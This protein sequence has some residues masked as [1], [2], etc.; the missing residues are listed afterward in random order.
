[1]LRLL[2]LF[3]LMLSLG[4]CVL[5]GGERAHLIDKDADEI[6]C[7]FSSYIQTNTGEILFNNFKGDRFA[8]NASIPY[9]GFRNNEIAF[10][11]NDGWR[12]IL[13]QESTVFDINESQSISMLENNVIAVQRVGH[14][15][16]I[17]FLE[18][19]R[20][21][22]KYLD[23]EYCSSR[24]WLSKEITYLDA[25]S[26][27]SKCNTLN[28]MKEESENIL[29]VWLGV[30]FSFAVL[31]RL[32]DPGS[33]FIKELVGNESEVNVNPTYESVRQIVSCGAAVCVVTDNNVISLAKTSA[34]G[35]LE[36]DVKKADHT[37]SGFLSYNNVKMINSKVYTIDYYSRESMCSIANGGAGPLINYSDAIFG[38]IRISE[39]LLADRRDVKGVAVYFHGGPVSYA[40]AGNEILLAQRYARLGYDLIVPIYS[41]TINSSDNQKENI[42]VNFDNATLKD[43]E[44]VKLYIEKHYSLDDQ[45][46][47]TDIIFHGVSWGGLYYSLAK[48]SELFDKYLLVA[49]LVKYRQPVEYYDKGDRK[50]INL[51]VAEYKQESLLGSQKEV[52]SEI[53]EGR[54]K[55]CKANA[56]SRVVLVLGKNDPI[57]QFEDFGNCLPEDTVVVTYLS[58]PHHWLNIN[59]DQMISILLN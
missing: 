14:I 30:N 50:G 41:G 29:G 6:Y 54:I 18:S 22:W 26:I 16:F 31:E 57:S 27:V 36:V 24:T 21:N 33:I 53:L 23:A 1:M 59:L 38:D 37:L 49:P 4:S 35:E 13:G 32:G 34:S 17:P 28:A 11:G 10:V 40:G 45:M 39:Y 12:M 43:F 5:I 48:E 44:A 51:A 56:E 2:F 25:N 9:G 42:R 3:L 47:R 46:A 58:M 7:R 55:K 8:S 15:L 19:D 52:V 20:N